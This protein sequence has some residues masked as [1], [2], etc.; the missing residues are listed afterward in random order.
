MT[1]LTNCVA[2]YNQHNLSFNWNPVVCI[3]FMNIKVKYSADV[4]EGFNDA[5]FKGYN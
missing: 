2:V 1:F 4:K 5:I 3:L